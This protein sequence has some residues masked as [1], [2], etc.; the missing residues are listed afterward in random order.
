MKKIGIFLI[1]ICI[2]QVVLAQKKSY[3]IGLLLDQKTTVVDSLVQKLKA[4]IKLTVGE[5]TKIL[6]PE[7]YTYFNNFSDKTAQQQYNELT[8]SKADIILAVGTIISKVVKN[9]QNYVKPTILLGPINADMEVLDFNKKT[10]GIKNFTY[11]LHQDSYKKDIEQLQALKKFKKLG[12]VIEKEFIKAL[13]L[14]ETFT[15]I[16]EETNTTFTLIPIGDML[17]NPTV[18]NTVD[19]VYL[20]GG[21]TLTEEKIKKI[22]QICINKKLPSFT[23]NARSYVDLGIM[24]TRNTGDNFSQIIRRLAITVESYSN[25]NLLSQMPLHITSKSGLVINYNT[26]EMVNIPIKY[27]LANTAE[28][29]GKLTNTIAEETYTLTGAIEKALKKNL[30]LL[31]LEKRVALSQQEVKTAKNNYLPQVITNSNFSYID[32]D[33]AELGFGQTPEFQTSGSI[34]INQT[35][36]SAEASA[37]I[38]IE[39]NL[40]KVAVEQLNSEELNTV[41]QVSQ[42]YLNILILKSNAEITRNNLTI[43]KQNFSIASQNF[44]TGFSGKSDVLRFK[45]EIAQNTQALVEIVNQ[46]DQGYFQ[47]NQL[48]NNP[49]NKKIEIEDVTLNLEVFNALQYKDLITLLDNPL[50]RTPFVEFLTNQAIENAPELKALDYNL[51]A[52]NNSLKLNTNG[53]FLPTISLQGNYNQIFNRNGKGSEAFNGLTLP[54]NNYNVGIA[55]SVPIFNRNQTNTNQQTARIQKEQLQINR[56]ASKLAISRNINNIV[57]EIIN[58]ITNID[59]SKVSEI[60]AKEVLELNQIS[61]KT[62]AINIVQLIDA[63]SNYINAKFRNTTAVYNYLMR[64]LELERTLGYFFLINTKE[65][66]TAFTAKFLQFKNK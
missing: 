19:A 62:G 30:N 25:G 41:F 21:Y 42:A 40:Q 6:F 57:L 13:P 43:S 39:K 32:P 18:L 1:S 60:S 55:V 59:L 10:S 34:N 58:Q 3:T 2:A 20:A 12:I 49:I 38:T 24:G 46:L 4:E 64:V 29:T 56:N 53:R 66:N 8:Y 61:Y 28:F 65:T 50:T 7:K 63:Q 27:S 36:F 35:I 15:R 22:A 52:V 9:Q 31:A 26:A 17:S 51:K 11:L 16:S 54:N 23:L 47:L 45:S 48:L 33:V 5:N 37:N 14:Q 44:E